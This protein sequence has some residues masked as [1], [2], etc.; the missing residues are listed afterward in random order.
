MHSMIDGSFIIKIADCFTIGDAICLRP[1]DSISNY[2]E[3]LVSDE[4][5]AAFFKQI[6]MSDIKKMHKRF[7]MTN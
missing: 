7:D 2:S 4:Q 6:R 3:E 1:N 5:C